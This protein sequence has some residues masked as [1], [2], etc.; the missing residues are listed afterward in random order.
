MRFM[1]PKLRLLMMTISVI[2]F[3]FI[4][5]FS[6]A[7]TATATLSSDQEDYPPG[8]TATL[9]GSGFA[10]GETV[11]LQVLHVGSD[12]DGTDPQY[13]EPWTVIADENGNFV[14]TWWVPNDGDAL[15]ASFKATADGQTSKL[16]AETFF[17]DALRTDTYPSAFL[18]F[19]GGASY[20]LNATTSNLSITW[21]NAICNGIQ[22][23]SN[24]NIPITITWYKNATNTTVG[25]TSVQTINANAGITSS[26]FNPPSNTEGT[27]FYYV[28]ISWSAGAN[29]ATAG[30]ITTSGTQQVVINPLPSLFS[31]TGGGSYCSGGSGVDVSLSGSETGVNYQLKNGASNVGSPIAGTGSAISFGNQTAIGTY[32][33]VA[34]NAA[35]TCTRPM[36]GSAI[37][38]VNALPNN[39]AS[40]GFT[41]G[42][43]CN[44]D[45]GSLSFDAIDASF[46]TPYTIQYT[47]GTTSWSQTIS[48]ASATSFN[49]AVNPT[50]TT[51]YSLV[52][53]TNGNG[54]TITTGFADAT[55]QIIVRPTPTA[56]IGGTTTVCQNGS[57]PNISFTNPQSSAV[58][59][60]Y[61]INGGSNLTIN[62]AASSSAN[63]AAPTGADGVFNYNLVSVN[64][65]ST[66]NCANNI[67]GTATITV[68]PTP[69][70]TISGTTTVCQNGSSPNISFTNP[71][72]LAERI[73]Y[74]INGG[75]NTTID[76]AGNSTSIVAASTSTAGTFN[77]NLVSVV[78]LDGS[79]G[80]SN[81]ISGTATVTVRAPA[82]ATISI[83]G[84][85]P[86]CAG[87]T[88]SIKFTGPSNGTVIYN[89][90]GGSDISASL[91]NGGNFVLTTAALT[92]N[93]TYNLVSAAYG[94]APNCSNPVTGTVT[95]VVSN[96]SLSIQ[97]QIN[98][99]CNGGSN[100]VVTISAT[101]GITPYQYQL[102]AGAVQAS[103]TFNNL[104]QGSYVVTVTD[105]IGCTKTIPVTITE[106]AALSGSASVTSNY[107]G[108]Q[109]SCAT[110]TDGEV[111]AS[112][113][114]GTGALQYKID[115]G[116][117]QSS[118]VF[119]GLAAGAHTVTVKDENGC[120]K[121]LD[122]VT[123][124]A[125]PVLSV[126]ASYNAPVYVGTSLNLIG[127]ISGGTGTYNIGWTSTTAFT[128]TGVEDPVVTSSASLSDA[129][130]Y[131]INVTDANGCSKNAFT[132]VAINKR[133]TS[134]VYSGSVTSQYSDQITLTATLSDISGQLPA[135]SLSGRTITFTVGSQSAT[136]TTNNLGI[137]TTA[138]VITQAPGTVSTVN[139]SFNGT[140]DPSYLSSNDSD[141]FSITKEDACANYNGDVFVNTNSASGGTALVNLSLV[142]NDKADGFKGDIHNATVK[143]NVL[144]NGVPITGSPFTATASSYSADNT[145]ATFSALFTADGF[146]TSTLSKSYDVTWTINN[147]YKSDDN[148]SDIASVVTV[149]VPTS[150]F[151]TGG[152]YVIL[153][154]NVYGKYAGDV[155]TKNNFGFSVKWNKSF[156]NIQGGGINTIIRKGSHAYQVKGTKVTALTVIP[157]N[158]STPATAGFTCNAVVNDIVNGVVVTSE[159]NCTAIVEITDVCEPGAGMQ[160]S[161]DLVAITVKDKN[162]VVIYSSNWN[163]VSKKTDKKPLNGG[164]LQIHSGSSLGAP[165]CTIVSSPV[166]VVQRNIE[167]PT[168]AI[169]G[170]V[171]LKAYP[172]PT[173]SGFSVKLQSSDRMKKIQLRVT[174]V[175]G[176]VIQLYNN[177]SAGQ[178]LQIGNTFR[179]GVYIIEMIQG[180][181][182]KELKLV[183]TPD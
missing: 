55:A 79:P 2:L 8:S 50:V 109:L 148:C 176:R 118:P 106:P 68:R 44:G 151:I 128:S 40:N 133:P 16:H 80:C 61:N 86:I 67:S 123:I 167:K 101:G 90:N 181:L 64:Y 125:P 132:T 163:A 19:T 112:V 62:V 91:N 111:T 162:G 152:G 96:I 27:V 166:T 57:S 124:T 110:S 108:S 145:S 146:S 14:T 150:D 59:I 32:T 95:V 170:A 175:S 72:A 171:D 15:G 24:T 89:I 139:A 21:S 51:N 183:K 46:V 178:V 114:G 144:Y 155:G 23:G 131:T 43:I 74:N 140:S 7:Q 130:T 45:A 127:T 66:P 4:T 26:T 52:S 83:N 160:A 34:T 156:S 25:G 116:D 38:T 73:T 154:N 77:Y 75:T 119:T 37:V 63:V 49:V 53:I 10:A 168:V 142:L 92:S 182:R 88:T 149:S 69:T 99:S 30:S 82:T 78:Y 141:P 169:E 102:D 87:S 164:N 28:T 153:D 129:G 47:D 136:A 11:T 76:V 105:N 104:S 161:S 134:L 58:T 1:Q 48:S 17:T 71:Q 9:T 174:D 12:P 84:S 36:T 180:D 135:I 126:S 179:P 157:A 81:S 117:Y 65:Q 138:L 56:S 137:A 54:C 22:N 18:T 147:Y 165:K 98:V 177:L 121:V 143:F 85:N 94:D 70:A 13:H 42:T 93:T 5:N 20:C 100:G 39:T 107:H 113:T 122:A 3:S 115:A 158:G 120:T 35:T 29:C 97:S 173:S 60:T 172:N 6:F 103:A 159:G 31:V 41:G 33:V